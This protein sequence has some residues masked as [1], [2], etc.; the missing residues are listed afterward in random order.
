MLKEGVDKKIFISLDYDMVAELFMFRT[1]SLDA[2]LSFEKSYR[3][4]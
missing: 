2:D 4:S 3:S 1:T